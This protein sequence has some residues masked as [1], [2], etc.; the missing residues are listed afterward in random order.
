MRHLIIAAALLTGCATMDRPVMSHFEPL[1]GDTFRYVAKTDRLA[2]R[3][4]SADAEAERMRWLQT[5]LNDN[6]LCP[7]GYEI[8]SRKPVVTAD[9]FARAHT[10]FYAGRC[11]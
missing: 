9:T 2:Y 4:D 7:S 3:E 10:I 6:K 5:Y 8:T 11:K 1:A